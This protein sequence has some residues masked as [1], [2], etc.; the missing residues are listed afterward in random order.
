MRGLH[1]GLD[2]RDIAPLQRGEFRVGTE[3]VV[4]RCQRISCRAHGVIVAGEQ[5]D[6][7][8]FAGF[9]GECGQERQLVGDVGAGEFCLGNAGEDGIVEI[10]PLADE[11]FR[12]VGCGPKAVAE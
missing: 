11:V 3:Q 6:I 9:F 7:G 12:T 4:E 2:H 1:G 10:E 8:V 5:D